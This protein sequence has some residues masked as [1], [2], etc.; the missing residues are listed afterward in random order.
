MA[1]VVAGE[2][3]RAER[4]GRAHEAAGHVAAHLRRQRRVETLADQD[5]RLAAFAQRSQLG[6]QAA[7]RRERH[8]PADDL[9]RIR[10]QLVDIALLDRIDRIVV[11]LAAFELFDRVDDALVIAGQH[12]G[13]DRRERIHHGGEIAWRELVG[14]E[15]DDR[16]LQRHAAVAHDVVVVKEEG[17][18]ARVLVGGRRLFVVPGAQRTLRNRGLR[19]RV[20]LHQAEGLR[21]LRLAVFLDLEIFEL[22][23]ADGIALPVGDDDIDADGLNAAAEDRLFGACGLLVRRSLSGGGRGRSRLLPVRRSLGGGGRTNTRQARQNDSG[24]EKPAGGC[25]AH[26]RYGDDSIWAQ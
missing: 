8:L 21:L 18:D 12:R 13:V 3:I 9:D 14:N 25:G 1:V 2:R 11:V 4:A 19:H 17:E 23:V 15:V 5:Q 26:A 20:D 22:E 7:N 6:A 16:L 10:R 24:D